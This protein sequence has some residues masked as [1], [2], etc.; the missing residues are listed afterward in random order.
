M[1]TGRRLHLLTLI[2][3][4]LPVPGAQLHGQLDLGGV[5]IPD[6][7]VASVVAWPR[8]L[9]AEPAM[10]LFP[11]EVV[12]A[13]GRQ[14]AGVD[15]MNI[16]LAV[17]LLDQPGLDSP[18]G[19]GGLVRFSEPVIPGGMLTG[20][21]PFQGH[22]S[23][24][25]GPGMR[26]VALDQRNYLIGEDTFLEKMMS[27]DSGGGTLARLMNQR[28]LDP[29]SVHA[30]FD[31]A[32]IRPAIS[33]AVEPD[34]IPPPFR[35]LAE[36]PELIRHVYLRQEVNREWS[37]RL[38][39][40]AEPGQAKKLLDLLQRGFD[41]GKGLLMSRINRQLDR[42]DPIQQSM[43]RYL[44]RLADY[45]DNRLQP[46]VNGDQLV[47]DTGYGVVASP[48]LVALLYP[49]VAQARAAARRFDSANRLRQLML[50]MHNHHAARRQLP[51][52]IYDDEG[53]PLLSWRVQILP[54]IEQNQL[55][56]QFRLDEPWDS[57][58]NLRLAR[59]TPAPFR[60]LDAELPDG[61]TNFL[62]ISGEQMLFG[63]PGRQTLATIRDGTSQTI[64]LVEADPE[65]AVIWTRPD[66][67]AV[68]ME[69]P[70]RGLGG[71]RTGGFNAAFLDGSV[72]FIS[73]NIDADTLLQLFMPD[74]GNFP[75][76]EPAW[77]R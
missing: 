58:H 35:F 47:F 60:C 32:A 51:T 54:Y 37:S 18:P 50:G 12:T 68:D 31:V 43:V 6:S 34:D 21:T 76:L 22:D 72:R 17:A 36:I 9:A 7:A 40:T 66:D 74:D 28:E 38:V 52:N 46:E 73:S 49:A 44:D 59:M 61:E 75:M 71:L 39:M 30:F 62:A 11:R 29:G 5:T 77:M 69:R 65:M 1:K 15:P 26:I 2:F 4:L 25:V 56:E 13:W 48:V 8:T 57:P 53:N 55:Y 45:L 70:F 42:S 20:S 23:F 67:L 10:E 27:P 41:T 33:T 64:G 24:P 3:C 16:E 63:Q 14:M 19:W